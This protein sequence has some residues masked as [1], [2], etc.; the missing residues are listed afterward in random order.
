MEDYYVF[1]SLFPI[2]YDVKIYPSHIKRIHEE[3]NI[4]R[5]ENI[6]VELTNNDTLY[7]SKDE[8]LDFYKWCDKTHVNKYF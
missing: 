1:H 7:V 6:V 4:T 3:E 5:K 8:I 2:P